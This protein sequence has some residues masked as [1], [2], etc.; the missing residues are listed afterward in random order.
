[1]HAELGSQD[2]RCTSACWLA[3][4][5]GY[6]RVCAKAVR[7][8]CHQAHRDGAVCLISKHFVSKVFVIQHFLTQIDANGKERG[9]TTWDNALDGEKKCFHGALQK[10]KNCCPL[11]DVHTFH[12]CNMSKLILWLNPGKNAKNA[13]LEAYFSSKNTTWLIK[14][15]T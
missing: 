6:L 9:Q 13:W 10:T 1:M 4:S 12:T 14:C 2:W 7:S 8:W 11:S 3:I 5:A 15:G